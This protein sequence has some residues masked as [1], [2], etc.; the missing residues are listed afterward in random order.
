MTLD[1]EH[2]DQI[3]SQLTARRD[4]LK[5]TVEGNVGSL[6]D[7]EDLEQGG[8]DSGDIAN[9]SVDADAK[10]NQAYREAYELSLVEHA[11]QRIEQGDYGSCIDCGEVVE[12][13]R[14]LANPIAKRCLSCQEKRENMQDERDSTPSL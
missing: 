2:L 14:L 13:E 10:I 4:E 12:S 6:I 5:D 3:R 9:Q 7:E 8:M 11:L 1:P